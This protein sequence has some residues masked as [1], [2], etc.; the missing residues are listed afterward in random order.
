[1]LLSD[2]KIKEG[3]ASA[4]RVVNY[5]AELAYGNLRYSGFIGNLSKNSIFMITFPTN[6]PLMLVP[7]TTMQVRIDPPSGE[8][9][10]LH[11]RVQWSYMTPPHRLTHSIGM[12]IIDSS[13]NYETLLT[14]LFESPAFLH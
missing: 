8:A 7:G 14:G 10:C 9:A 4:K 2:S 6:N 11:C 3:S 1:M 5:K 13:P 12:E